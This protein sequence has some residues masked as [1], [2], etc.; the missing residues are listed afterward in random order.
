MRVIDA[1]PLY[2]KACRLEAQALNH[3]EKIMHDEERTEEWKIWSAILAE[4]TA[5]KHDVFDAPTIEPEYKKKL[6]EIADLLSEKMSY[7]NTCLN[8]RDIIL[9]YLGVE[10]S[11]GNHCN[12]DCR[13]NK[14]ESYHYS[15]RKQFKPCED[16]PT[17]EQKGGENET[18]INRRT[19]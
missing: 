2:E 6:K 1:D 12:T 17:I 5:F 19:D 4:R 10:R 15:T 9:G 14:C 11:S 3:I 13:N 7:M 16:A 8:E 18:N